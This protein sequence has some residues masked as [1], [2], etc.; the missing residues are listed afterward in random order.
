MKNIF[1][2]GLLTLL[3]IFGSTSCSQ[4]VDGYEVSP[5]SPVESNPA[6]LTTVIEVA[7]FAHFSGEFGRLG[8]LMTQQIIGVQFQLKDRGNYVIL[9]GDNTNEWASHYSVMNDCNILIAEAGDA[10][11]YY[12]G[13]GRTLK[14]MNL[15]LTTDV[16]GD[17]PNTQ[18]TLG[19]SGEEFWH[20]MYD[21]QQA[22]YNDIQR[23]LT[24]AITDFN[25]AAGDNLVLPAGDDLIFNGNAANWIITANILKARAYNHLSKRDAMGSA[26]N[27]L[28][29]IDAAI[30]AG[31]MDPSTDCNGVYP[32]DGNSLNQWYAFQTTRA[33]YIKMSESF[34]NLLSSINDPR[35]PFYAATDLNGGISG[36]PLGSEDVTT[37]NIGSYF[38]SPTSPTPM[39]T[40]VEA[41]FIEAEAALRA[42]DAQRA[43]DAHNDAILAHVKLVTGADAPADYVMDQASETAASITLEKIMTHKY[44]AGF[45]QFE[46][47]NDWRRTNIPSL[48]PNPNGDV[49]EIP[50]RLPTPQTERL[51]NNNAPNPSIT[52]IT[53]P[54][55]WDE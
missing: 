4:F 8:G 26:D 3:L 14:A 13:I 30:A 10:N 28:D 11:P 37:S 27:A 6:L 52:D 15:M 25:K 32:G 53:L 23:L 24:D 45:T 44:V 41:K 48:M 31:M 5:N 12:R 40:Y 54:V 51:Y 39:V 33:D 18:A 49:S 9:E 16:W 36:T 55:W 2:A 7:T 20:P 50:R 46:V 47:W 38:A 43:A 34:V 21:E 29:A 22:I 19:F 35:L 17:V 42:N 1:N